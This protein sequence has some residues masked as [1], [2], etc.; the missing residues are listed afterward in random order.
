MIKITQA[1][2]APVQVRQQFSIAGVAAVEQVGKA[3]TLVVDNSYRTKGP[4]I[5]ADGSWEVNFLFTQAGDRRLRLEVDSESAETVIRVVNSAVQRWLNF[6]NPPQQVETSKS[7]ILQGDAEG[8]S[9]GTQLLLR[10]DGIYELARPQV[11]AEK[12]QAAIGFTKAGNRRIEVIGSG[13]DRA[14]ITLKVVAA[15]PPPPRPPRLS[16][17]TPPPRVQAD[18]AFLLQGNATDYNDGDQLILRSDQV[19]ELARPRVKSG[20]WEAAVLLRQAGKRLVE[21][22]GSEQDRAQITI[23]VQGTPSQDFAVL[24]RSTWTNVPTP[25]SLPTLQ[26]KRITLHHTALASAPSVNATQAQEA[27]RMRLIY[28]SHVYGNG[29]SD[30]GYH[31]IVMPSGRVFSARAEQ[32][33]GAHDQVNDGLGISFDGIFTSNTISEK[34]YQSAVSLCT[35]LCKRYGFRNILTP[36][37]TPTADFGTKNLPLIVGHRDRVQTACPGTAGGRTVRMD[38]IRRAVNARL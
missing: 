17:T 22:L 12:W 7:I 34:Q 21:V 3:L 27:E 23:E 24:P 4:I 13:E 30:I 20:K 5:A 25:I 10:A 1:P 6:T 33:R 8:Y 2:T 38:E 18:K 26:P 19:Y 35:Q 16:F 29:W 14:E 28:N 36:V 37:P 31:F 9:D 32:R 15:A 11:Q